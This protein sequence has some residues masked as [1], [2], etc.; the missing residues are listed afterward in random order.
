MP[1]PRILDSALASEADLQACGSRPSGR[2]PPPPPTG[3]QS[4][5][6]EAL[7]ASVGTSI[8]SIDPSWQVLER[9]K[10]GRN[11]RGWLVI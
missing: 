7:Y 1:L 2:A 11:C 9:A 10:A 8:H 5:R 4:A 6:Q 3:G